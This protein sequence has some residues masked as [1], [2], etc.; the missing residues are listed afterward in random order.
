MKVVITGGTGF[1]G[2]NLARQ[3]VQRNSLTGPSGQ[4]Q[5]IDSI[6]LFDAFAPDDRPEGL[7]ERVEI[8]TGDISDSQTVTGLIDRDDIS[9]FH[10]AS[11]VSGQ[12]ETDFDLALSVNLQGGLNLF[13]AARAREGLPRVVFAS[14]LAVFG[15]SVMP[16][17]VSDGTKQTAQTTYGVTKTIGELLVN[18]YS[19]KGFFD[20]RSARLPTIFVRPGKPNAAASSFCSG[21]FREPLNGVPCELPVSTDVVMPMLGYRSCVA[22][23]IALHELPAEQLGDDRAVG[24]RNRAYSVQEM[25]DSV[26]RVA[27]QNG[28][29]LGEITVKPDPE[30]TRIVS[31]WAS[32]MDDSRA[33]ALG[34]PLDESLDRVVQDFIDDFLTR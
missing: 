10:L 6:V 32:G 22:S 14:S 29:A 30:I 7:D 25:I 31:S 33:E 8:T 5:E 26:T 17:T 4:P 23:F 24:L 9:I 1:I 21:V 27:A 15:G 16:Q 12:G 2:L 13:E 28:I 20:G 3:L 34:L 18:D 19:R 11:V